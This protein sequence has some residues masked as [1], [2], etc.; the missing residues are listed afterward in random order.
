MS[1][2]FIGLDYIMDIAHPSGKIS[3]F[4]GQV[5]QRGIISKA[6]QALEMAKAK[7]W[8]NILVKVGFGKG[9][10]EQP[11]N[12][13][14]FGQAHKFGAIEL[15][16]TGTN[17]HP[18]LRVDL[19]DIIVEK[20]RVS[21]FYCTKLEAVLR[22]NKISRLIVAG[23]SST[24]AVQSTVRDAHDRDYDILVLE[25]AC[26]AATEEEHKTSMGDLGVISSI[27]KIENVSAL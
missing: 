8:L 15:G 9:Y 14:L 23:V 19:S 18:D 2:A 4:A 7:Q 16:T 11:K 10:V 25:D 6:N 22:S 13:L 17:F 12:S 26:A 21:P 1:T 24:W 27:I 20:P 5:E 3:S